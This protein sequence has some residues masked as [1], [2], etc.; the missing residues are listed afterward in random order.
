MRKIVRTIIAILLCTTGLIL[1]VLPSNTMEAVSTHGDFVMDGTTLKSYLGKEADLTLPD[2]ITTIGKDAFSGNVALRNVYIPDSVKTID[3]AAFENCTNLKSVSIPESVRTIGSSAFSGCVSLYNISIPRKVEQLGSGVFAGCKS[4]STVP[5]SSENPNFICQDGVIYSGDGKCLIQ[6]LAGRPSTTYVMPDSIEKIEEY[7]FWG[8]SDLTGISISSKVKE[9]PE[10]AFSNCPGLSSV[11]IP[12][13]VTKLMAYSFADCA[14]LRSIVIPTSVG[15]IDELAF[16]LSDGVQVQMTEPSQM[17][18]TT[19]AL[20]ASSMDSDDDT[21]DDSVLQ[22]EPI[23][24]ITSNYEEHI[25]PGEIGSAIVVGS[26]ATLL[27]SPEMKV[28][29]AYHI[30]DAELEDGISAN[31]ITNLGHDEEFSIIE[32]KL[33]KYN[34]NSDEVSIPAS[35]NAIGNRV[36]YKN[37]SLN[38]ITIPNNIESIGDFAFARSNLSSVQIPNGTKNIGYAAFYQCNQLT[39]V[40]IPDSVESIELGAFSGTPWLSNWYASGDGNY[41]VVGNGILLGYKGEGG[42]ISLPENVTTIA[43]G[44]FEG[45]NTITGVS[46]PVG[47]KLIGEDAFNGCS[48]LNTISLPAGLE[49]I[50]DRAFKNTG[51]TTL[52]IPPAV[53]SI[54]LGAFDIPSSKLSTVLFTGTTL[55]N[56]T[57]KPTASRLSADNLR[58]PA[59]NGVEHALIRDTAD[60]SSGDIFD[61]KKLGFR[62]SVYAISTNTNQGQNTLNLLKCTKEP[63]NYGLVDLDSKINVGSTEYVVSGVKDT[64][65]DDYKNLNKWCNKP[66]KGIQING[67]KSDELDS[68]LDSIPDYEPNIYTEDTAIKVTIDSTV[69]NTD[70]PEHAIIEGC[71]TPYK[72]KVKDAGEYT[73]AFKDAFYNAYGA[74]PSSTF[75]PLDL[76]LTELS[77]SIPIKKLNKSRMEITLP[78]P[79]SLAGADDLVMVSLNDNGELESL[80]TATKEVD[81]VY[82]LQFVTGHFSPYAIC[83]MSNLS[84]NV[85]ESLED[86]DT[87]TD[88]NLTDSYNTFSIYGESK[89]LERKFT[90]LNPKNILS[91]LLILAGLII[92]VYN[93]SWFN[94]KTKKTKG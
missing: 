50:E 39:D 28:K 13:S 15:Y 26:S 63:D 42:N 40:I 88:N 23:T 79:S 92:V 68:L 44:C 76:T 31:S 3:Y 84:V 7:S 53:K 62:G 75:I 25:I 71:T 30:N 73:T 91:V 74:E 65:F 89:T 12:T 90:I 47:T 34:G 55:P 45:N 81:G 57:A 85:E 38:Q 69:L 22:E 60:L 29:E 51:L 48:A 66:L 70:G 8:A 11:I 78:I 32:S 83:R 77:G 64:A 80:S 49:T 21:G 27:I 56:V 17:P 18:P 9:I 72:L 19:A 4:L 5:I 54:G 58:K 20:T 61:I 86:E 2:T 41:L 6:Y 33:V 52:S 14:N 46:F 36:F 24:G 35:I 10:Y 43:A 82:C 37:E 59:F 94:K 1:L 93:R 87:I 67:N 16:Y